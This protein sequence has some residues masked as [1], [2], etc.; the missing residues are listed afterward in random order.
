MDFLKARRNN[1]CCGRALMRECNI[2]LLVKVTALDPDTGE[3]LIQRLLEAGK[4][5]Y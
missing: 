5:K 3:K 1:Y 2:W 4:I